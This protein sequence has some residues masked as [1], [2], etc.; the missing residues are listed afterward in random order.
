VLWIAAGLAP[1]S[2]IGVLYEVLA[3]LLLARAALVAHPDGRLR[4]VPYASDLERPS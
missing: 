4:L 1:R 3:A 2:T